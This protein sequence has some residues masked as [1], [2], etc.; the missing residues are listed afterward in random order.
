V[1]ANAADVIM[2]QVHGFIQP[3]LLTNCYV[4]GRAWKRKKFLILLDSL[5]HEVHWKG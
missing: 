2:E 1:Y 4:I 3:Y 5:K